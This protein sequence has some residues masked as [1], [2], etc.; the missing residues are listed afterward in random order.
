MVQMKSNLQTYNYRVLHIKGKK[1]HIADELSR[2]LVW[3]NLDSTTGPDEGIEL[4][5]DEDFAMR[6]MVSKPHLLRDN[7][8]LK[9]LE[10]TNK[11]DPE[12]FNIIH[13]LRT[14]SSN[15]SIPPA[16]EA[17]RMGGEWG[18]MAIMQEAEVVYIAVD[19]GIDRIYPPKRTVGKAVII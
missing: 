18:K 15:K 4:K 9:D 16:S 1:N 5:E 10:D 12:Y 17:R 7:P 8:L 3:M 2:R 13:A 6:V 19:D 11:K 14:G